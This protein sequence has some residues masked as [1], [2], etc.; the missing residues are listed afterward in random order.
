MEGSS[1]TK[2]KHRMTYLSNDLS[3]TSCRGCPTSRCAASGAYPDRGTSSAPTTR[4]SRSHPR[5][6]PASSS[7]RVTTSTENSTS[8]S[9]TSTCWRRP[10]KITEFCYVVCNPATSS[11]LYCPVIQWHFGA[12]SKRIDWVLIRP[13]PPTYYVCVGF[14]LRQPNQRGDDLLVGNW[15]LGLQEQQVIG[16]TRSVA[17]TDDSHEV[18][19][20][21]ILHMTSVRD[22]WLITVDTEGKTWRRILMSYMMDHRCTSI[23]HSQ[24]RLYVMHVDLSNACQLSIWVLEDYSSEQWTLKNTL[25]I[26][27]LFGRSHRSSDEFYDVIAIH[28]ECNLVFI[29]WRAFER[30][31]LMSYNM[32]NRGV[33]F[34]C[35]LDGDYLFPSAPYLTFPIWG[36]FSYQMV[37]RSLVYLSFG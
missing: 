14:R 34:I 29:I 25:R 24:G 37:T 6:Y 3:S 28:P 9:S 11:G 13:S 33:Q 36:N 1:S 15:T 4:S 21:G 30:Q 7:T 10:R 12:A 22:S 26:V 5:P 18:F 27:E 23:C 2:E 32:D 16:D 31:G 20:N 35:S 8:I 19:F 17:I